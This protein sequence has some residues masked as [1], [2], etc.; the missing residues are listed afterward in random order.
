MEDSD[1]KKRTLE[2][3]AADNRAGK[4]ALRVNPGNRASKTDLPK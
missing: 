1:S 3:D 2:P 4:I